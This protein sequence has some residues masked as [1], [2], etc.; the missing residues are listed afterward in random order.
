MSEFLGVT[1]VAVLIVFGGSLVMYGS[2][3]AG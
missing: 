2:L 1:A 3:S